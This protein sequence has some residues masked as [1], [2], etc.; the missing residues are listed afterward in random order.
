MHQSFSV[1][2]DQWV[3]RFTSL[4]RMLKN[5]NELFIHRGSWELR[6]TSGRT[7][8]EYRALLLQSIPAH[9]K[10]AEHL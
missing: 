10:P 1:A 6:A 3:V 7:A 5:E 2:D 4:G 8:L 9:V